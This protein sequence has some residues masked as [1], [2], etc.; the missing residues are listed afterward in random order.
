MAFFDSEPLHA[1][2][3]DAVRDLERGHAGKYLLEITNTTRVPVLASLKNRD[4]LLLWIGMVGSAFAMNMQLVAQGWLVYEM[5]VSALN[6]AWV[7]LAFTVPQ[8]VF[9]LAGGV[10][11]DRFRKKPV[12]LVAQALNGVATLVMA[13]I[14]ITGHVSFWDFIW[15]GLNG[16]VR[17]SHDSNWP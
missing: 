2:L 17:V 5:T 16:G 7:T 4:Y 1:R 15:V 6:L 11:A 3:P 10:F 12:I 8:V 14:V 13:F 9:S